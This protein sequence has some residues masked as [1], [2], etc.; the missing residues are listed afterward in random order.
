[1]STPP[2]SPV[3]LWTTRP[4]SRSQILRLPLLLAETRDRP[5]GLNATQEIG[6]LWPRRVWI[7][8]PVVVSQSLTVVSWPPEATMDLWG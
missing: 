8:L 2:V 6:V 5:S 7:S 1:M 4:V 3:K